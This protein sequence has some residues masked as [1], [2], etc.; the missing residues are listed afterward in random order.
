MMRAF[1]ETGLEVLIR[2]CQY[3]GKNRTPNSIVFGEIILKY[4]Y[5]E[6]L[7]YT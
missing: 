5:G 4:S 2:F 1:Y 7:P 3:A 6:I